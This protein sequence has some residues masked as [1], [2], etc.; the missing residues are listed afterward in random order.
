[1]KKILLSSIAAA[2]L[3]GICGSHAQAQNVINAQTGTT[4]TVVNG[5]C[6]P[7]GQRVLT[8]NNTAAQAVTLPQAGASGLF[9]QGC[10]I[11]INNIGTGVVTITPT[12]STINGQATLTVSPGTSVS[13]TSTATAAATGDYIY[14]ISGASQICQAY[15]FTGTPAATNQAFVVANRPMVLASLTHVHSVAAGGASTMDVTH[16]SGTTAP[17]AGTSVFASGSFDLNA[18]ANTPQTASLVAALATRTFTAGHRLSVKFNN[19]I[20]SSAG[21]V[22]EACFSPI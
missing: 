8:F 13:I 19:T 5:D 22:V 11:T 18:T 4:Y 20:Q 15:Y 14:A 1:M 17:G 21:I 9:N 3:L 7:N 10:R 2:G 12:T 16:E 6:D